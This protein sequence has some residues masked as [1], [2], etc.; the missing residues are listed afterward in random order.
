[1]R[2]PGDA[3]DQAVPVQN[4]MDGAL[5][6]NARVLVQAAHQEL[7]NLARAPMGFL[8]LEVNDQA[9]DLRRQLVG[10]A[11]WPT[12]AIAQ[13]LQPAVLIAI[14]DLVAG[15]ARD[16]EFLA[17]LCH[18]IAVEQFGDKTRRSSITEHS[19]HGIGTSRLKT[20]KC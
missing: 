20:G 5:C 14:E 8:A 11:H 15:L 6:R 13:R 2:A 7:A 19:F 3:L 17:N 12:R 16:S 4:G 10:V 1:M 9:F 18:R